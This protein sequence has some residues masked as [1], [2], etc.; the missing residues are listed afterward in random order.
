VDLVPLRALLARCTEL[1]GK[2]SDK[3]AK[4]A[5]RKIIAR[6]DGIMAP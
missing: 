1:I 3:S 2:N 6:L 4:S 5:I